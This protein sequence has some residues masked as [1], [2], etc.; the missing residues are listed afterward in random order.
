MLRRLAGNSAVYGIAGLIPRVSSLVLAPV[1]TRRLLLAYYDVTS[2]VSVIYLLTAAFMR[3]GMDGALVRFSKSPE[4]KLGD[5]KSMVFTIVV[6]LLANGLA[7]D[8]Q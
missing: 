2:I 5:H 7:Q 3:L 8:S 4:E 6:A 1:L